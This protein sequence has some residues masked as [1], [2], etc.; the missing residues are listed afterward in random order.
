[1]PTIYTAFRTSA[2]TVEEAAAGA[3]KKMSEGSMTALKARLRELPDT[4]WTIYKRDLGTKR[5]DIIGLID[6]A[7]AV[8][9]KGTPEHVRVN[10]SGQVRPGTFPKA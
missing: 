8:M 10:A 3:I 2:F 9:K 5:E 4:E 1:M 6:D 7:D